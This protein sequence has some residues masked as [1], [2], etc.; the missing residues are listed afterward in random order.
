M[1]V[2]GVKSFSSQDNSFRSKFVA[3]VL[4]QGIFLLTHFTPCRK[5]LLSRFCSHF[6]IDLEVW[7]RHELKRKA[8]HTFTFISHSHTH[9]HTQNLCY[10]VSDASHLPILSCHSP[11]PAVLLHGA[12]MSHWLKFIVYTIFKSWEKT[13]LLQH[14]TSLCFKLLIIFHGTC[15]FLY[16]SNFLFR[17]IS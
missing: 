16:N 3:H 5:L 12:A 14:L 11:V 9:T 15:P 13:L 4:H 10:I 6:S 7:S 17:A 8:E 2:K 1:A